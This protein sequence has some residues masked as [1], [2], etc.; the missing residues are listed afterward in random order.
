MRN[1]RRSARFIAAA[2]CVAGASVLGIESVA[3]ESRFP[4]LRD[5]DAPRNMRQRGDD[6]DASRSGIR[7]PQVGDTRSAA[8]SGAST[9][10]QIRRTQWPLSG[11]A[12][13]HAGP[14][15]R[16]GGYGQGQDR[17]SRQALS[18]QDSARRLPSGGSGG[19]P[20]PPEST[21]ANDNRQWLTRTPPQRAANARV[22]PNYIAP[23]NPPRVPPDWTEIPAGHSIRIVPPSPTYARGHWVQTNPAGHAVD[24]STG[25][26]P[27][28]GTRAQNAAR[29]HVEFPET[30]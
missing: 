9:A 8:R 13:E 5:V 10:G 25:R 12:P 15:S 17:S 6:A 1:F 2:L 27:G 18:A 23:T 11:H 4:R 14:S 24:P 30:P 29:T 19:G 26:Q 16:P 28:H 22:S 3:A 7:A 21:H 20:Q